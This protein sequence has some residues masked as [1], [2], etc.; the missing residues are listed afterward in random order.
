MSNRTYICTTCGVLRRASKVYLARQ[1][2]LADAKASPRWPK[3]CGQPM[4][5]LSFVQAEGATQLTQAE[6]IKWVTKGAHVLRH[7]GKHKWKP[8]NT[9]RQIEDAKRQFAGYQDQ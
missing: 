8:A 5:Q 4:K 2:S 1:E 3:H 6:R 7:R 9:D